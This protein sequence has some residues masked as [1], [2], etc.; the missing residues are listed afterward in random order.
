MCPY[1]F[2]VCVWVRSERAAE[3]QSRRQPTYTNWHSQAP[4][5]RLHKRPACLRCDAMRSP[6]VLGLCK[7]ANM[8]FTPHVCMRV[9]VCMCVCV[10]DRI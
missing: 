6:T 3:A 10:T 9:R 2:H 7:L 1:V 8:L 5:L 4:C